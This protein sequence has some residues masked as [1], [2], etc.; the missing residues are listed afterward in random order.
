VPHLRWELRPT[1]H[2]AA[3]GTANPLPQMAETLPYLRSER[4]TGTDADRIGR[5]IRIGLTSIMFHYRDQPPVACNWLGTMT[6]FSFK[7]F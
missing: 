3:L 7:I 1:A 5:S 4:T 6:D 2:Q